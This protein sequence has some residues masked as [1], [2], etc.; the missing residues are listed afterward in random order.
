MIIDK[1][2]EKIANRN[3]DMAAGLAVGLAQVQE[4]VMNMT[5]NCPNCRTPFSTEKSRHTHEREIH[6]LL[7]RLAEINSRTDASEVHPTRTKE[8]TGEEETV[9]VVSPTNCRPSD[10]PDGKA[11][12]R[13]KACTTEGGA[14]P[15]LAFDAPQATPKKVENPGRGRVPSASPSPQA[16]RTEL[17]EDTLMVSGPKRDVAAYLAR[18]GRDY[19]KLTLREFISRFK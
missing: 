11:L 18:I 5:D 12:D 17:S 16:L 6:D 15:L 13:P 10:D 3:E 2:I 8:G 14:T 7:A 4:E 19:G 1:L 9:H